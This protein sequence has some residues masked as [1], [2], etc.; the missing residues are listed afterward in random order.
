[1][2]SLCKYL[3]GAVLAGP[4]IV[5]AAGCEGGTAALEKPAVDAKPG[6]M[7]AED[8][9]GYKEMQESNKKAVRK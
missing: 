3:A 8:M 7:K 2:R 6:S 4:L 5:L 9:P 1:M